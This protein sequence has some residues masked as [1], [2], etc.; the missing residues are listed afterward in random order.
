MGVYLSALSS[1]ILFCLV[2][3]LSL[4]SLLFSNERKKENVSRGEERLGETGRS[5]GREN[6]NE[7]TFYEKGISIKPKKFKFSESQFL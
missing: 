6:C 7:C 4:R 1:Y 3:L 2:W 5:R